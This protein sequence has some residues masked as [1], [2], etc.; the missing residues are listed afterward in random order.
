MNKYRGISIL[1]LFIGLCFL[2]IRCETS[3]STNHKFLTGEGI[4]INSITLMV[5]DID[6]AISYY[7]DT[8]GFDIRTAPKDGIFSGTK[9]SN[10]YLGDFSSF[11]FLAIADSV[12]KD[13]ITPFVKS[14]LNSHQ[15]VRLFSVHTSSIDSTLISLSASGFAM[16]TIHQ[17]QS[18]L[19]QREGWSRDNPKQKSLDFNTEN[20][21]THLPR[22][23]E[24]VGSGYKDVRREWKT[25]YVSRRMYNTHPNGVVG[26]K[27]IRVLVDNVKSSSNE[28]QEMGF[29]LIA[30]TDAIARFQLYKNHEIH[31]MAARN[32]EQRDFLA[33]RG[34]GVFAIRFDVA[35]MD[36]TMQY[37]E[38]V[39]SLDAL[40]KSSDLLTISADYAFGVQLEFTQES[41]EQNVFARTY[42]PAEEL[43]SLA[44]VHSASLYAKYCAL[45]HGDNREGYT[46]DN[47]PSLRSKSL[48]GTSMSS[49]FMRYTIQY[50]RANTPWLVI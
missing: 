30:Q 7:K 9:T 35:H 26:I 8:L 22:F 50:G 1:G 2:L 37:F 21:A 20:P 36:S 18:N 28:F 32:Q 6:S 27:A 49:N 10:M 4:G 31:L 16:D 41:E 11:E 43:D 25:Y 12:N 39:V 38:K 45:C 44:L 46:A 14:F 33:N 34:E 15:G 19:R 23:I 17:Y 42:T 48:L 3:D 40:N 24:R 47:A 29:D 13:S 5:K